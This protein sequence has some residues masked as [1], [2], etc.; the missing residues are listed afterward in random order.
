MS[1]RFLDPGVLV[2]GELELLTPDARWIDDVM[3]SCTHPLCHEDASARGTTRQ[4]LIDFLRGSPGGRF[5][6][7]SRKNRVP[8]Y[9]FWMRL[10]PNSNVPVPIAGHVGL[11]IGSTPELEMY[12]GHIGYNVYP[13]ARGHHYAERACRLLFPLARAHGLPQLWITCNPDNIPSRR[14]CEHLGGEMVEIV[15]VPRGHVLYERGE[16]R[17]CRYRIAL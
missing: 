13:P 17:K 6:G 12:F 9:H 1:F 7:D 14:T 8:A 11:R 10:A 3:L 5:P 4:F 16:R 2:D 15:D